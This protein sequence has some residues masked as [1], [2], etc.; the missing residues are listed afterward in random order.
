MIGYPN[1]RQDTLLNCYQ[2]WKSAEQQ[3]MVSVTKKKGVYYAVRTESLNSFYVNISLSIF[4]LL[5]LTCR[6]IKRHFVPK[7]KIESLSAAQGI[8]GALM[9]HKYRHGQLTALRSRVYVEL[10]VLYPRRDGDVFPDE[11]RHCTPQ[12]SSVPTDHI[13]VVEHLQFV[14][15]QDN[16]G[17]KT[18]VWCKW[19]VDD[20]LCLQKEL[21]W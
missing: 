6:H 2:Y 17:L 5:W 8:A 11:A 19:G 13:F 1:T 18:E 15:L 4:R 16:C 14:V 21:F 12:H 10:G 20:A 7:V 3:W 9:V